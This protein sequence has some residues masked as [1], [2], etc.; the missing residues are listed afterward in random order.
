LSNHLAFSLRQHGTSL[1]SL[2]GFGAAATKPGKEKD[3]VPL[4]RRLKHLIA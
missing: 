1:F 4:C 3:K 2:P